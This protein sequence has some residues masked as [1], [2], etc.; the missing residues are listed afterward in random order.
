MEIILGKEQIVIK[1]LEEP[2]KNWEKAF[3]KMHEAG[4][5]NLITDDVISDENFENGK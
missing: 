2:R 3:L 4:D 5:D 1:S